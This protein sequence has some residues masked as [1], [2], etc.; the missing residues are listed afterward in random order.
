MDTSIL[1]HPWSSSANFLWICAISTFKAVTI[2]SLCM[3]VFKKN[4]LSE[5][6]T[7]CLYR[8]SVDLVKLKGKF[9]LKVDL[10]KDVTSKLQ[11]HTF[12]SSPVD[13]IPQNGYVTLL[14][15]SQPAIQWIKYREQIDNLQINQG[16]NGEIHIPGTCYVVDGHS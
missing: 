10:K 11:H 16:A 2:A 6:W 12:V 9:Y 5:A 3:K 7:G 15:Y 14:M 13:S 4:F 1:R 8:K